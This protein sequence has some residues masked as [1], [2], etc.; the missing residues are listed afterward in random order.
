MAQP[1]IYMEP[2]QMAR[3]KRIQMSF[4]RATATNTNAAAV[5]GGGVIGVRALAE[6]VWG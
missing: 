1:G 6:G 4:V 5:M 2:G 3:E